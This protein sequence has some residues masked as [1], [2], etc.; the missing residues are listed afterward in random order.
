MKSQ[1]LILLILVAVGAM[2][3]FRMLSPSKEEPAPEEPTTQPAQTQ[4]A[5]TTSPAKAQPTETG[6]T[7]ATLPKSQM[8]W[9]I[10]PGTNPGC[11]LGALTRGKEKEGQKDYYLQV[12]LRSEGAAVESVHLTDYFQTVADKRLFDKLEG[13]ET[14]YAEQVA[15]NPETY[16]GHYAV[17][18][19]VV[20]KDCSYYAL[21]TRKIILS[22]GPKSDAKEWTFD[23]PGARRWEL[24]SVTET[25]DSQSAVFEWPIYRAE[26][27]QAPAVVLRKT[28]TLARGSYS[29][30]VTFECVN[31]TDQPIRLQLDQAGPVGVTQEDP[32]T[33]D[34]MAVVAR[35][36]ESGN[37]QRQEFNYSELY[38]K[39]YGEAI[40]LGRCDAKVDPTLWLAYVNKFFGAILYPQPKTDKTLNAASLDAQFYVRPVQQNDKHRMWQTGLWVNDIDLA[41]AGEE[42]A[43]KTFSFN[44]FTGPKV[45]QLFRDDPL[46]ARLHYNETISTGGCGFCTFIWLMEA[47]M[48]LLNFFAKFLFGNFGLAII[49]LV[50]IVRV[51]LHP[52]MKY[53]QVSMAKMQKSM[54]ALKPQ[55]EKVREKYAN[56]RATQQREL[57]K[58]QKEAGVGPGQMLGCLPML[59]QMPIWIALY[60]GLNTEVALRHEAFLPVWITDLAAP[61]QL[62]RFG[63]D[64]PFVGEYFNLLPL[65]LT[66]AMFL[67]MKMNPTTAAQS[68]TPEQKQQQMMMKI[69]MPIM[70]LFFFYN[71]PS[72][73]TLY[74]MASTFAGVAESYYIRKHIRQR[75]E[76][77]TASEAVVKISGKG[78]RAARPRKPKG[79]F[80]TKRG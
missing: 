11:S 6:I 43:T 73:L 46:Y 7:T 71:A 51:L 57:L 8:Q 63:T 61:D 54:A 60:T 36:E 59:L 20:H 77:E 16:K 3:L 12:T 74:I 48:W 66:V 65:L 33:D 2:L 10:K 15:E 72:G 31:Q 27:L 75:E 13:D 35:L 49:L 56:D 4:P 22:M 24:V 38:K 69:M 47:L 55:M 80:W 17:L 32:R 42:N 28:Y 1:R 70:M 19:P 39:P 25:D 26:N 78:P 76:M 34:R 40:S 30:G 58:L 23:E 21:A 37:I 67:S 62:F 79:P 64:L 52:L 44:L 53:S 45:R 50:V 14:R 68:N 29:I 18:S 41:P 5:P 9:R